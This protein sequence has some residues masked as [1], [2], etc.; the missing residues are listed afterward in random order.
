ML[1][2]ESESTDVFLRDIDSMARAAYTWVRQQVYEQRF[3]GLP[4]SSIE[5]LDLAA[6]FLA[7]LRTRLDLGSAEST[8]LAYV[9]ALMSGERIGAK[10]TAYRL[11]AR[12]STA[13][14]CS[15]YRFGLKAARD[16]MSTDASNSKIL[17]GST[18]G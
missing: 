14:P 7:G 6:G 18:F 3:I 16:L 17:S 8:M 13:V 9:Y 10:N 15:G 5:E 2:V 11:L 4:I 1:E 12:G